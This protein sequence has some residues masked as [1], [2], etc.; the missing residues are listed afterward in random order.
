VFDAGLCAFLE[1]AG[2]PAGERV[3]PMRLPQGE[4]L[5]AIVYRE[6]SPGIEYTQGGQSG[7]SEPRYQ[8]DCW[9]ADELGAKTLAYSVQTAISGYKGA[10]GSE[11]VFAAFI[12]GRQD[13]PD[14]DTGRC[15]VILDVVIQ[16]RR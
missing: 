16:H 3:F 5:P 10:M 13:D 6:V 12:E 9:G 14:P 1:S 2:T 7:V 11:Q 8:L 15:R 4:S